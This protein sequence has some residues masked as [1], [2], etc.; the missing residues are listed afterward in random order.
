MART[1]QKVTFPGDEF[2]PKLHCPFCGHKVIDQTAPTGAEMTSPCP[3]TLFITTDEG[4]EYM[5]PRFVENLAERG[6]SPTPDDLETDEEYLEWDEMGYSG[7]TDRVTLPG[8]IKFDLYTPPPG[9]LSAYI[10]FA[11]LP[12]D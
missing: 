9:G 4:Y 5:A 6:L 1:I 3:H 7:V 11:P 10:G 12:K 8:A 2:G